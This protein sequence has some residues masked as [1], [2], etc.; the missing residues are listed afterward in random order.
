MQPES[1]NELDALA[2]VLKENPKYKIKI[3][4]FVNK[5][6]SRETLTMGTSTQFFALDSKTNKRATI[7]AKELSLARAETIKAYL[8]QQGI[9]ANRLST[10]GE[11]GAVP[12]YPE[13]GT[14]GER[15]DRVEVEF[16]K[17]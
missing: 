17:H 9:E 8:V 7:S 16:V 13:D 1:Q 5:K 3:F 12:L 2:S 11:G 10:K 15:N 6:Q 4:G 14:L